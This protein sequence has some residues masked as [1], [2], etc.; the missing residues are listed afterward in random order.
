MAL[1]G[2]PPSGSEMLAAWKEHEDALVKVG[3]LKREKYENPAGSLPNR[4][5]VASYDAALRRM[6]KEC[7]WW[8]AE[9]VHS[10]EL[11][12]TGCAGG[13]KEWEKQAT[14]L[15]LRKK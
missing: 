4:A 15:G 11:A 14:D 3:F 8:R 5:E 6:E 7:K 1:T 2:K 12:V 10:N 13:L 9:R